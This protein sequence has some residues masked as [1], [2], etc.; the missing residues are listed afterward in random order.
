[1]E[2]VWIRDGENLKLL[3]HSY[4]NSGGWVIENGFY[5]GTEI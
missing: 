1:V 5:V 2:F 4:P 3:K